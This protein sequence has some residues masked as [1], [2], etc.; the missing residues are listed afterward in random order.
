MTKKLNYIFAGA[1]QINC[2]TFKISMETFDI[3]NFTIK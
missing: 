2:L 1:D 3:Q